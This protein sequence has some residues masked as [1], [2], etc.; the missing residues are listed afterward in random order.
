MA[1]SGNEAWKGAKTANEINF[2]GTATA[3]FALRTQPDS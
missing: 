2:S 1:M 3:G